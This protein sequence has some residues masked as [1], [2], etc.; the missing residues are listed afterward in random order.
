[1]TRKN[2]TVLATRDAQAG[3][4]EGRLS[5]P[6]LSLV[7][8]FSA[9][10]SD[11]PSQAARNMIELAALE[12]VGKLLRLPYWQCLDVPDTDPEVQREIEDWFFSL[13]E[14]ELRIFLQERLRELR[15]YDGPLDGQASTAFMQALAAYRLALGLAAPGTLDLDFFRRAV[16]QAVP[17][18]RPPS[19]AAEAAA[20]ASPNSNAGPLTLTRLAA[21]GD[22][23]GFVL[24][25]SREGYA[26]C[27]AHDT[28]SGVIRRVFPNRFSSDPRLAAN[29][30]VLLQNNAQ[31]TLP[32]SASYA[33]LH[34]ATDVYS[35]LP[36]A[37]RW[38]DFE[39]LRLP[40]FE[41]LR[42]AFAAAALGPVSLQ[43]LPAP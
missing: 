21:A 42:A 35:E 17:K 9:S 18:A 28:A 24:S 41:A 22:G 16:T 39:P 40:T 32:R 5:N 1:M 37:L 7:F 33:C 27:Y 26:Y 23:F 34:A 15:F 25:T 8:N 38:G 12:L 2:Q 14:A 20:A 19:V 31:M 43:T 4:G 10:R 13:N 30:F 36:A 11:G 29:Q 6:G 3:S